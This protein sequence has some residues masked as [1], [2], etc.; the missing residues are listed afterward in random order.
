MQMQKPQITVLDPRNRL[1]GEEHPKTISAMNNLVITY[2]NL[3]KYANAEKLQ[4][5]ALDLRN[6]LLGE[7]HPDTIN[8][9]NI[10]PY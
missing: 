8:A 3:G 4:I 5:K 7:E 9:M 10:L 6:R 2:D 1:L